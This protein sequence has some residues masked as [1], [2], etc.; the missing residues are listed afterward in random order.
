MALRIRKNGRIVCAAETKLK[1][2]DIYIG[3]KLHYFLYQKKLICPKD[4]GKIWKFRKLT[5]GF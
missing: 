2:S 1:R 3:D 5:N 4:E